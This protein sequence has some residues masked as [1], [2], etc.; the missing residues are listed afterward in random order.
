MYAFFLLSWLLANFAKYGKT[1]RDL[2]YD[3]DVVT[4]HFADSTSATG[5]LVLGSD[6]PSSVVR[7][8]LVGP[9]AGKALPLEITHSIMQ[10]CYNDA[11]KAKHVRS[12]S[13]VFSFAVA[14]SDVCNFI[15]IQDVSQAER[16]ETWVFTLVVVKAGFPDA[17]LDDAGRL[18]ILKEQCADLAEPVGLDPLYF[19]CDILIICSGDHPSSGYRK[20][21]KFPKTDSGTGCHNHGII[22]ME[23]QLWS[24]TRPILC[25]H[26]EGKG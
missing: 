11:A 14:R 15:T 8:V 21:P 12:L 23:E 5:S 6:G 13:P 25:L 16:P 1:L 7:S 24:E 4:A 10:V 26:T 9:E 17:S 19:K 2:T 3:N 18:R 22:V 20:T